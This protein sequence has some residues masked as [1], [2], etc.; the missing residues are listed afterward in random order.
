ML[1]AIFQHRDGIGTRALAQQ[2]QLNVATV[3]NIAQTFC[4]RGYLRQDPESKVFYPGVRLMLLGRHPTY[5]RSL[6]LS[7]AATVEAV[8]ARLNES[9]LLASIDHGRIM[10]LKYVPSSQA[11]RVQESEDMS[12]HSYATAVGKLLLASFTDSELETY[13]R[14]TR[15]EQFTPRT[16]AAPEKLKEELKKVRQQGYSETNDEFCEGLSAVAVAIRD[17]WGTIVAGLGASAPTVRL[18][19]K[20]QWQLTLDELRGAVGEIE[21]QWEASYQP[22]TRKKTVVKR[23]GD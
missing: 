18:Q 1:E 19:K 2:M 3:H 4:A 11:L 14:E 15:L 21:K 13:L 5:L 10:N 22:P 17:P 9:V 20:D 7:A 23:S 16:L 6:S 8:A 12:A